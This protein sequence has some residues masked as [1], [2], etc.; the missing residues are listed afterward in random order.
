VLIIISKTVS[1]FK[2]IAKTTLKGLMFDTQP[3]EM[4]IDI[5]G[6]CN[7]KCPMCPRVYMPEN[8]KNGY[9]SENVFETALSEAK[10]YKIKNI[11]LYAT[12]EPTLH[13]K[14]SHFIDRLKEEEINISVS[15]NAFTLSR[16]FTALAKI[17]LL[18]YSVEGWD[19]SSYELFREP[20]NF[21]KTL[22]NI[23]A[24]WDYCLGRSSRPKIQ[25]MM[26]VTK[27]TD[28]LEYFK[29]W[30]DFV[31]EVRIAPL[32]TTTYFE[33]G[34]FESELCLDATE[35]YL[36]FKFDKSISCNYPFNTI[37]V[38]FDG[39]LSL[40]CADFSAE[41]D[42]GSIYDGIDSWVNNLLMKKVRRQFYPFFKKTFCHNCNRFY[43]PTSETIRVLRN[44]VNEMPYNYRSKARIC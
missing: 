36:P 20:L 19:K 15:T 29:C 43:V 25:I 7:A 9:M 35:D 13:P 31:D 32:T 33:N 11:R 23:S 5:C 16:H 12:G 41:M 28:M 22:E 30:S 37:T 24:F 44:T 38:S 3:T 14:F 4:I 39:K 27:N 17:G 21:E 8:R 2:V 42:L 6:A 10:K 18:Q 1:Q 26:L 40:C 34:R